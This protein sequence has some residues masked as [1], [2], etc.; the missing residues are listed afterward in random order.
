MLPESPP[1]MNSQDVY[2]ATRAGICEAVK[3]GNLEAIKAILAEKPEL[4]HAENP[5][6]WAN[7]EEMRVWPWASKPAELAVI[8]GHPEIL[9]YLLSISET[10]E[11]PLNGY[12]EVF[13]IAKKANDQ[14]AIDVIVADVLRRADRPGRLHTATDSG[15][16]FL[17][18]AAEFEHIGL[19]ESLLRRGLP[20][21]ATQNNGRKPI[22]MV[23]G[24]NAATRLLLKY[25]AEFDL[26]VAAAMG[27]VSRAK[28]ILARDQSRVNADFLPFSH[29]SDGLPMVVA[30]THGHLEMV[31]L[32]LDHGANVDGKLEGREFG[33]MGFGLLIAFT[34]GHYDLVNLLLDHG[35][36]TDAWTDSD[37]SFKD[38]VRLSD[39]QEIK[40]RV[41]TA[42]EQ[43][44]PVK[45]PSFK[46]WTGEIHGDI[47]QLPPPSPS[48]ALGRISAAIVSH[49]RHND[50][51]NYKEII[52][53]MLEQGA[54]QNAQMAPVSEEERAAA[55]KKRYW[56]REYGDSL[57]LAF[58]SLPEQTQ[59]QPEP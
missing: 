43:N 1:N 29:H 14:N 58:H 27:D 47:R 56:H 22:H 24:D 2:T 20:P 53:V 32:L 50:Y 38:R 44:P 46:A 42:E 7:L 21:D 25:G 33:D 12:H 49:N 6:N 34:E 8:F 40:D 30:A 45:S 59:L 31:R 52:T 39:V 5:Y 51:E 10:E 13:D 15:R 19:M 26:W 36:S 18:F 54:D 55:L 41:L 11:N 23:G 3:A 37:Y 4:L 35:A 28:E 16:T 17:H 57:A 48:E 9:R